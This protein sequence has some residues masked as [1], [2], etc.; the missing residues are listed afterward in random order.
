MLLSRIAIASAV[1]LVLSIG[2]AT[3]VLAQR[4]INVCV[5]HNNAL[6]DVTAMYSGTT[7]DTLVQGRPFSD[8]YPVHT[9]YASRH[10]WFRNNENIMFRDGVFA[11]YGLPRV[12]GINEVAR[13]G[14][15]AGVGVY[16]EPGVASPEVI[17]LP[18]RPGCEFQPY[19]T[20]SGDEVVEAAEAAIGRRDY[21]AASRLLAGPALRNNGGALALRGELLH[22]GM[23]IARDTAAARRL[24]DQAI[25]AQGAEGYTGRGLLAA[26]ASN[27]T[28]AAAWYRSGVARGSAAAAI[29]LA[30]LHINGRRVGT[31]TTE[32]ARMLRIAMTRSNPGHRHTGGARLELSRLYESGRGV[33]RDAVEWFGA[34]STAAAR[35]RGDAFVQFRMGRRY[36][37]GWGTWPDT[38]KALDYYRTGARGGDMFNTKGVARLSK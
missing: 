28:R 10:T 29:H 20:V 3:E 22:F 4:R 14:A 38:A 25:A 35:D 30:M 1:A 36:E 11:K 26:Q 21:A 8:V 6:T 13:I 24:Y 15:T 34:D 23:G 7:G 31:D 9:G 32:A 17:Y 37:M 19:M 16:A 18:V 5:V 12:L 33:S 2:S 27:W